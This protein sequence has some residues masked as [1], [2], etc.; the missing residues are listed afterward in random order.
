MAHGVRPGGAVLSV[1]LAMPTGAAVDAAWRDPS[2][3][4]VRFVTMGD[5][6]RLEVLDWGGSGRAIVLLAGGGNTAHAFDDFAP[7]LAG[8]YRV[9]GI[10]RRGW[11]AS[12]FSE[13]PDPVDR[14]RADL[15][16]VLDALE[17]ER[18]VLVGHS[19]AG[20]EM[21]ALANTLL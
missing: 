12:G 18:P 16:S 19:I 21:S 11:G 14:L 7:L 5:G 20:A 15:L 6:V 17:V 2:P 1:L 3:H 13:S 10:T 9:Y 4:T 8:R